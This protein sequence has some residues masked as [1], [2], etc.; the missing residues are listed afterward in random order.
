MNIVLVGANGKMGKSIIDGSSEFNINIKYKAGRD[1]D[2]DQSL[3]DI[4]AVIDFSLP[5]SLDNVLSFCI[6][7]NVPLVSGVTGYSEEEISKIKKAS[8][9]I[10]I[11]WSPNMSLGIACFRKLIAQ[12]KFLKDWD[13]HLHDIHHNKKI[14]RPSGTAKLLAA[15]VEK[16][17]GKDIEITDQRSGG[18]FGVHTLNLV[19]DE[20][21]ISIT[22]RAFDRKVFAKGSLRACLWIKQQT[23]GFYSMD[24]MLK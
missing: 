10:A 17:I 23:N 5:S 22:H 18:V 7:N 19:S 8:Q 11:F 6:K 13:F 2:F 9:K 12:L 1:F 16:H 14:D 24:D 20:E 4:S 21:E 3:A 15:E